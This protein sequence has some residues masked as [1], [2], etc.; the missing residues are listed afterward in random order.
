MTAAD[1]KFE[2]DEVCDVQGNFDKTGAYNKSDKPEDTL[3]PSKYIG[4]DYAYKHKVVWKNAI[5][6]LILH[7][8]ALWGLVI[9]LTGQLN[10]YTYLWSESFDIL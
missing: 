9:M 1:T 4:T 5:G 3:P 8:L 7:M 10:L 2:S 6:F